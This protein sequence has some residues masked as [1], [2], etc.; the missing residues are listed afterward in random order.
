MNPDPAI[1]QPEDEDVSAAFHVVL[2]F[3][4]QR[5][6]RL[7]AARERALVLC[8]AGITHSIGRD[9][10]EWVLRAAECDA[11]KALAEL[12]AY[13]LEL[14]QLES[15]EDVTAAECQQGVDVI[16]V[17][18][19]FLVVTFFLLGGAVLQA[20]SGDAWRE[21]GLL[22]SQRLVGH[23]EWW[24][25]LTSLTLHADVPHVVANLAAGL[26]FGG[27]LTTS[28]G[29]GLAWLLILWS[30]ALGNLLTAWVYFPV[31][32]RSLGASTAVFGALGLLV[33]DA[34]AQLFR[35]RHGRSWWRWIL[36]LGAGV[37]LLA[38]LGAGEG[39]AS[40]DVLAHLSGFFVGLPLGSAVALLQLQR[41]I[42]AT[43]QIVCGVLAGSC[44][45]VA[46]EIAVRHG[47]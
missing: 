43:A 41:R 14:R 25:A 16:Q 46:W 40:V 17:L 10:S 8:A 29:A 5:F 27:W 21:A 47:L 32:H 13:E 36:P 31:E 39:K 12:A 3:E 2:N 23:G 20:Q 24:R 7:K 4:L 19:S 42:S 38:Y 26:L 1:P 33:G 44:F 18:R 35:R 15:F 11:P 30:G 45:V 22:S 6:S 34:L 28:F 37:S 9:G